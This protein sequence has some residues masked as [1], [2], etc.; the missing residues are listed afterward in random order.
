MYRYIWRVVTCSSIRRSQWR[1]Y[2]EWAR[3]RCS[4]SGLSPALDLG[5]YLSWILGP[6]IRPVWS[7][8]S[9]NL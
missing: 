7:I 6:F 2:A 1:S 3:F 5:E 8:Y 9:T 4:P